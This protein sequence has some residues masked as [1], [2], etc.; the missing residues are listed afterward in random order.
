LSLGHLDTFNRSAAAG[1]IVIPTERKRGI[2]SA[3][4]DAMKD[5]AFNKL[6]LHKIWASVLMDNVV[7]V[8][9]LKKRGWKW[10]GK[11]LNAQFL[12]GKWRD[13]AYFEFLNPNEVGDR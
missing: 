12:D 3:C 5:L 8:E 6:G 7:V 10:Q 11:M 1:V 13:R 9:A 4:D 2:A